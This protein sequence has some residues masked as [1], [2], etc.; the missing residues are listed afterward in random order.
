M[1][2]AEHDDSS[3]SSNYSRHRSCRESMV[4]P[5]APFRGDPGHN[6]ELHVEHFEDAMD[7]CLTRFI[8]FSQYSIHCVSG[9]T[10]SRKHCCGPT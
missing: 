7:M 5:I 10:A 9:R 6:A 1:A 8:H 2:F 4:P 3:S